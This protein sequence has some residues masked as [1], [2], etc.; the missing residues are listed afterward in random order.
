MSKL[1]IGK[2]LRALEE[3]LQALEAAPRVREAMINAGLAPPAPPPKRVLLSS[4]S[5]L[6]PTLRKTAR[7][8]GRSSTQE[9]EPVA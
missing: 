9:R 2:Q 4:A 8:G 7:P 1:T 5:S 6:W 3:R